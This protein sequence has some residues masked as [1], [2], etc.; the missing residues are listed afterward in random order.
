MATIYETASSYRYK[1]LLSLIICFCLMLC[2]K[3]VLDIIRNKLVTCKLRG[4]R[5]AATGKRTERDRIVADF[6]QR[7]LRTQ[8][9]IA[10]LAVHTHNHGTTALQIAHHIAHIVG[11][12]IHLKIINRLKNL[13]TGILERSREGIA[14]G[15]HERKLV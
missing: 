2:D 5:S 7:N 3:F 6:L 11:R 10:S 8:L 4:K 1:A 14:C 9:L 13:R 12:N 15:E